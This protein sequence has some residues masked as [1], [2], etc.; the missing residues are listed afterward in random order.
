[1]N[2]IA[3][4]QGD[5]LIRRSNIPSTAKQIKMRPLALGEKTGHHHSLVV[6]EGILDECAELYEAED[7]TIYCRIVNENVLLTHQEHKTHSIPAGDYRVVIQQE[8]TD[9]GERP[10]VD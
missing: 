5:V 3:L 10:V 2:Q 4:R 1:M 8:N 7:G 6:P 9:W